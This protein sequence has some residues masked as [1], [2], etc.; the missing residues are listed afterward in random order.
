MGQ[1][2]N[3]HTVR[4]GT[5]DGELQFGHIHQD[6]NEAA[7][8]LRSGHESLHY[9]HMDHTGDEV[10]KHSTI[11]R[12][13]GSFQVK[14]GDNAK[15]TDNNKNNENHEHF[16]NYADD[17]NEKQAGAEMCQ[18]WLKSTLFKLQKLFFTYESVGN[19]AKSASVKG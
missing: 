4:Y 6:N 3:Y 15:V 19:K 17:N 8:M 1:R 14:A 13:T 16:K 18:A 12:S 11:C 9:I 2:K 5:R 10:R 7:V